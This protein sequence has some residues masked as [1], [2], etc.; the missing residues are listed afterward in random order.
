MTETMR[1]TAAADA[2]PSGDERFQI[3]DTSMKRHHRWPDTLI[4]VLHTAQDIFGHL[5]HD[6]LFYV[7]QADR[8]RARAGINLHEGVGVSAAPAAAP[9]STTTRWMTTG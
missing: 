9:C 1:S 2:H 4:E 3:I 8:L 5:D 7:A 6:I